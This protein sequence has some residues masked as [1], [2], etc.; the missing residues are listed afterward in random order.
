M[1]LFRLIQES[2]NNLVKHSGATTATVNIVRHAARLDVTVHDDGQ[3]FDA[4]DITTGLGLTGFT[5][6]VRLLGGTHQIQT[7]PG[8]GT[9][10]SLQIPLSQRP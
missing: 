9:T 5:E 3:G 2:L 1:N 6:R 10:V 8:Q 4:E 7:A